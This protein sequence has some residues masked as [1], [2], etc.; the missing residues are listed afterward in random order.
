MTLTELKTQKQE[1]INTL[2]NDVGVFFAFSDKQLEEGKTKCQLLAGEKL[3]A[4][5]GGGFVRLSMVDRLRDGVNSILAKFD[6]DVNDLG[7]REA[8]I[9]YELYNHEAFYTFSIT[10]TVEALGE[11]YTRE[12]VADVFNRIVKSKTD[13]YAD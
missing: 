10:S 8:L 2:F 4:V 6:K 11:G 9:E 3:A 13:V 1:A 7:L 12:E 5:G